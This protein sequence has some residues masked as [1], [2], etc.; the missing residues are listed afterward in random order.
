L[1]KKTRCKEKEL[2]LREKK[3]ARREEA[4]RKAGGGGK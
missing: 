1:S 4:L 3:V 2:G